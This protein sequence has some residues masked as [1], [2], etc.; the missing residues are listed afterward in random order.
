MSG[1]DS[2]LIFQLLKS[3]KDLPRQCGTVKY[4]H[5]IDRTALN[6]RNEGFL[7][8]NR[9]SIL[10]QDC[11]LSFFVHQR[12]GNKILLSRYQIAELHGI[13]KRD[14]RLSICDIISFFRYQ[15]CPDF[16]N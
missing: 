13:R 9:I 16:W 12:T 10:I 4:E 8:G 2:K 6:S 1:Y 15:R 14:L 7:S 3:D 11:R 5:N